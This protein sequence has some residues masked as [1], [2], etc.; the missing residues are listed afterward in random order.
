MNSIM[1]RG[2]RPAAMRLRRT[3]IWNERTYG[4]ACTFELHTTNTAP[5][6]DDQAARYCVPTDHRPSSRHL[7]IRRND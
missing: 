1:E 3:L 6:G 7:D 2:C 4:T 5:P